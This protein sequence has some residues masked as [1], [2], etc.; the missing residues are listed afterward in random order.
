MKKK[1]LRE[2]AAKTPDST[3]LEASIV[4][5]CL[6]WLNSL[7]RS[8]FQK[9]HGARTRSGDP[10][11][12]G[13]L[14]SIHWEIEVKRPGNKPTPRQNA[15]LDAWLNAGARACWVESLDELKHIIRNYDEL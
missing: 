15:R 9:R 2:I 12:Y 8:E 13:C 10:D 1:S 7:P 14:D 5:S 3:P 11:I 6:K 4:K